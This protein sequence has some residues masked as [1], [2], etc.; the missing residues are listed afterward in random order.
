MAIFKNDQTAEVTPILVVQDKSESSPKMT[1]HIHQIIEY[2]LEYGN[3]K[4]IHF[5]E[6]I[7]WFSWTCE[8]K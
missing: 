2:L 6:A 1:W 4:Q 5:L 8:S 7:S 3:L